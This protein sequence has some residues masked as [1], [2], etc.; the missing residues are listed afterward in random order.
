MERESQTKNPN[1][2]QIEEL[3]KEAIKLI[4]ERINRGD[5]FLYISEGGKNGGEAALMI[6]GNTMNLSRVLSITM[7]K[8][9]QLHEIVTTAMEA[10][11]YAT[12]KEGVMGTLKDLLTGL[13][14]S[15]DCD[16]CD[17]KDE[18]KIVNNGKIK[19]QGDC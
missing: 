1:P 9:P 17:K 14:D 10:H 13:K 19:S 4:T 18:C 11:D 5:E 6:G 12:S 3:K 2:E 8:V 7:T 15:L 16:N